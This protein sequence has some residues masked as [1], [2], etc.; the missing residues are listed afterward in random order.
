MKCDNCGMESTFK[1][2]GYDEVDNLILECHECG[3]ICYEDGT[4]IEGEIKIIRGYDK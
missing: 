3:S 2:L 4:L 1:E